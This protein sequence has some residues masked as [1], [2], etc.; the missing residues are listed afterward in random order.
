MPVLHTAAD[1]TAGGLLPESA[2]PPE[3]IPPEIFEAALATFLDRRR[4][5]MRSL[6]A[7]LGIGRATLYR[8]AGPR[9]R[10]LG[11][12][13]W[14][15]TRRQI[16]RAAPAGDGLRGTERVVAIVRAFMERIRSQPAF[17][18]L[19]DAEPE[20]AL[21]VL[22]SKHGPVQRGVV[23]AIERLLDQE[24]RDGGLELTI[25]AGV[26]A[27]AIV[28]I[29][30]SFLYA[31]VIADHEADVEAAVEVIARLLEGSAR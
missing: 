30:E 14:F 29:G 8:K 25:D 17:Q 27:Y 26:L 15:L 1:P 21:R 5:D 12:V 16:V 19:L 23:A 11:E 4:I 2:D 31:D 6:A 9:D 18:R 22:T 13:L 28:R 20:I 24:R 10:L 7:E 3:T